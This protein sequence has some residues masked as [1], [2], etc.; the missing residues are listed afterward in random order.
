MTIFSSGGSI[1]C[2]NF[3]PRLEKL[4]VSQNKAACTNPFETT[5]YV[6]QNFTLFQ[7]L[8]MRSIFL[9]R[10]EFLDPSLD[11]Y[12]AWVNADFLLEKCL[13]GILDEN[14]GGK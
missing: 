13:V 8:H 2:E 10:L 9:L 11:K 12:H 4:V 6:A 14:R 1:S 5:D 7:V 3:V